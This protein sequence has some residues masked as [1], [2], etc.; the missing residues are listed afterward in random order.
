M[1]KSSK[2][3]EIVRERV[4]SKPIK[5]KQGITLIALVVTIVILLILSGITIN[6]LLGEDGIIR[7]AQEAKNTWEGA[8]TNEQQEIQNLVNEFNHVMSEESIQNYEISDI[9]DVIYNGKEYKPYPS[10]VDEEGN[11]LPEEDYTVE[12][13]NNIN[14]GTAQVIIKIKSTGQVFVK[15]FTINPKVVTITVGSVVRTFDTVVGTSISL[16]VDVEGLINPN[17]LGEITATTDVI[18]S[19]GDKE[20]NLNYTQN[21]NYSVQTI[22]RYSYNNAFSSS[23]RSRPRSRNRSIP[24]TNSSNLTIIVKILNNER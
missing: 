14:V 12:Y 3:L 8:I 13:K 15:E 9:D 19:P 22:L 24:R 16:N 20:I 4:V 18:T 7:T 11:L 5:R 2:S 1:N 6:M 17:D 23:P 21:S 10:L